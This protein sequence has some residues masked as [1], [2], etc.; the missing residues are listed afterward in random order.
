MVRFAICTLVGIALTAL[1]ATSAFAQ[2][3]GKNRRENFD[4]A[5]MLKRMDDNGNGSI[6]PGEISGRSRSFIQRAAER[7][8]L[9]MSQ[10]MAID[11][12]L[13][14]MQ[15]IS[16][17]FRQEQ[18]KSAGG[19]SGSPASSGT[20][21]PSTTAPA[22]PAVIQGFDAPKSSGASGTGAAGSKGAPAVGGFGSSDRSASIQALEQRFDQR[23]IDY[24]NNMLKEQDKNGDGAIDNIE[25]KAG[26]WSTPPEESDTNKDNR[27]SK[28]E[29]C[30]RISKRFNITEK[31]ASGAP[32]ATPGASGTPA[33]ASGSPSSSGGSN[34]QFKKYAES[35]LKQYDKSKD[36]YLQRDEYKEM[37]TEHQ[38]AD[39]NGD[40]VITVDEL[41]VRLAAY[42][43]GSS[44]TAG[45]PSKP[46]EGGPGGKKWWKNG[47][48]DKT[49]ST[50]K[51]SY[52]FPTPTERLPKGLPDWFVR[53]DSDGDG[54]ILMAEYSTSWTESTAAEF[55]K[56]DLD[57][58][59]II[60]P[61]E[62]LKGDKKK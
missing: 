20:P 49:A 4:S 57:G 5:D 40:N 38:G 56:L 47:A 14:A 50:D 59:G 35:L 7:A 26:R 32:A 22:K 25:W 43:S 54:Q 15:Q 3:P 12:L 19:P 51:K 2:G 58:D 46:G 62:C 17:E 21:S 28:E 55:A 52:R 39:S 36:G 31:T 8:K 11:K 53:N 1:L 60:T 42:S 10:P 48:A 6:E 27:L 9:D 30:V 45:G 37:K 41:A 18:T 23:V 44:S 34:D 33:A 13:P 29:L 61:D 24:V 16:E